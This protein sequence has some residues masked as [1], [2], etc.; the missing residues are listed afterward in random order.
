[1]KKF[2]IFTLKTSVLLF[3]MFSFSYC[4]S[5]HSNDNYNES[6][7]VYVELRSYLQSKGFVSNV[8][9]S[10]RGT[11]FGSQ[12]LIELNQ[13]FEQKYD[14]EL[15]EYTPFSYISMKQYQFIDIVYD[16]IQEKKQLDSL[17]Q[18][19]YNKVKNGN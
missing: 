13:H 14:I 9:Y 4:L 8:A 6:N 18:V 17:E 5:W 1:M 15:V 7:P 2:S 3:L 19:M 16:K 11:G 12:D 10:W